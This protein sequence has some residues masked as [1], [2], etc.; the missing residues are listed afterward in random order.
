MLLPPGVMGAV[1]DSDKHVKIDIVSAESGDS[2]HVTVKRRFLYLLNLWAIEPLQDTVKCRRFLRRLACSLWV[3]RD[4]QVLVKDP[5]PVVHSAGPQVPG[6]SGITC[7]IGV[8]INN[9]YEGP[10]A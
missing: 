2:M 10:S 6:A 3:R 1:K 4:Q 7:T 9:S 5:A 8:Q